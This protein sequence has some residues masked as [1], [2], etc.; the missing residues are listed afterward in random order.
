MADTQNLIGQGMGLAMDQI[1]RALL[2]DAGANLRAGKPVS[3]ADVANSALT[4][5]LNALPVGGAGVAAKGVKA[6]GITPEGVEALARAATMRRRSFDPAPREVLPEALRQNKGTQLYGPGTYFSGKKGSLAQWR[7]FGPYAQKL[8]LSPQAALQIAR[9]KGFKDVADDGGDLVAANL[10][11]PQIQDLINQGYIGVKALP[12]K[13][14]FNQNLQTIFDLN[15]LPNTKLK[16]IGTYGPDNIWQNPNSIQRVENLARERAAKVL[17][18]EKRY[19]VGD[20]AS[21]VAN[22]TNKELVGLAKNRAS[23]ALRDRL[24]RR[25]L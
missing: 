10:D 20:K 24:T 15:K 22:Q 3:G 8:Q 11:S 4:V 17:F 5:G 21:Y 19:G 6:T 2:G 16:D 14:E 7:G 23:K 13:G 12:Q 1:Y 25:A 9:S 18:P